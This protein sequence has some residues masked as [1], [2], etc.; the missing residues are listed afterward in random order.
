MFDSPVKAVMR[1]RNL[2]KASPATSVKEAA[3]MMAKKNTGAVMVMDNGRLVGIFTERDA[4]FRVIAR[5]LDAAT[6]PLGEVMTP[7]PRVVDPNKPYGYALA[8]MHENGFRHLPVLENGKV[9][10]IVS[11]RSAM[12]PDM[13]E[14]ASEAQRRR[15]YQEIG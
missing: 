11:A 9:V 13:E 6:T 5:G 15:H 4:V 7:A 3:A 2:L 14:F 10:G 12:D 8:I 1:R